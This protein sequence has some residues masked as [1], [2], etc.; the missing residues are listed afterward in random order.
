MVRQRVS[1]TSSIITLDLYVPKTM[2]REELTAE[3]IV[4]TLP[5]NVPRDAFEG[6]ELL[7]SVRIEQNAA[8]PIAKH[9][10]AIA[11]TAYVVFGISCLASRL[12]N[13][14]PM[15]EIGR[16]AHANRKALI[17]PKRSCSQGFRTRDATA[18]A[19]YQSHRRFS[20]FRFLSV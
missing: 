17:S 4:C 6:L 20:S 16:V 9:T 15:T 7:T 19:A 10:E 13:G 14:H 11:N 12:H 18:P 3:D 2:Y 8:W 1:G 5:F